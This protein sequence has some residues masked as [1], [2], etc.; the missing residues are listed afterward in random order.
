[1]VREQFLL[2]LKQVTF[3]GNSGAVVHNGS[4]VVESVMEVARLGKSVAFKTPALLVPKQK[5]G[6]YTSVLHLPLAKSSNYHWFFDCLPRLYFVLQQV[7]EPIKIIMRHDLPDF[8]H[9]TLRFML[10]DHPNAEVVYIG[11][12]E[13]WKV[14][15][16]ILPS[17]MAN[18]QS[19][20][21]PEE[22]NQWLQRDRKS[23]R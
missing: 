18:S 5:N 1:R 20:Y 6:L 15:R 8:Q 16:F 17:F 14:E 3:L 13:K 22:V 19:A 9:Q 7:R 23:T 11:K 21:L 10:Q 12:Y 2:D 4:I